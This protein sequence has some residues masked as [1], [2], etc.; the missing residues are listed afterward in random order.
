MRPTLELQVVG[1]R[2][3]LLVELVRRFG[4]RG[5]HGVVLGRPDEKQR[6][7]IC[8]LEVDLGRRVQVEVRESRLVKDLPGLRH[9]EALVRRRRVIL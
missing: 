7:A 6:R 3:G 5:Q 2:R 1:P 4:E 8:V 9:G